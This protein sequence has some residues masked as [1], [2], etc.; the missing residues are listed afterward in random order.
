[1]ELSLSEIEANLAKAPEIKQ[2]KEGIV[3]PKSQ[4]EECGW[5]ADVA[6]GGEEFG[7]W[8]AMITSVFC[9][10]LHLP[11]LALESCWPSLMGQIFSLNITEPVLTT[12]HWVAFG[13]TVVLVALNLGFLGMGAERRRGLMPLIV[14]L[15]GTWL[16]VLNPLYFLLADYKYLVQTRH[17]TDSIVLMLTVIGLLIL[18]TASSRNASVDRMLMHWWQLRNAH[19]F[20]STAS[21]GRGVHVRV[22]TSPTKEE[23]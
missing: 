18:M 12:S 6:M 8:S 13:A 11:A 23:E 16:I 7:K 1:M 5:Q 22:E 15:A 2:L 4:M 9:A 17:A 20:F 3:D 14:G 21:N 19:T 10:L